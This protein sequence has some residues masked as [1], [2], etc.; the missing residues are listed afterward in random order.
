MYDSCLA[1]SAFDEVIVVAGNT[2]LLPLVSFPWLWPSCLKR[3][4]NDEE[5]LRTGDA[6]SMNL[7]DIGETRIGGPTTWSS[8]A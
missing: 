3:L 6:F 4:Y 1:Q 5:L 2:D 7:S 8:F